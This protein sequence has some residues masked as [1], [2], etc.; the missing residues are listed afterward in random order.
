MLQK[1]LTGTGAAAAQRTE[2]D[3]TAMEPASP[4]HVPE[5]LPMELA[6]EIGSVRVLHVLAILAHEPLVTC[7]PRTRIRASKIS[8]LQEA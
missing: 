6:A 4:A 8:R 3:D 7:R 2:R 1:K 5:D